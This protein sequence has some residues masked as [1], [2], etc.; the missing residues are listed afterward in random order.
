MDYATSVVSSNTDQIT[1]SASVSATMSFA[2]N[3]NSIALGTLSTSSV[4]SGNVVETIS[5]NARNGWT[6]WVKG[7]Q[8]STTLGALRS[9]TALANISVPA[10]SWNTTYDLSST[11][12]YVIDADATTGSPTINAGYDGANVTSGGISTTLFREMATKT[13]P[14][15]GDQVTINA[16]AKILATQ[17]AANDYTDTLTITAAGSF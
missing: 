8:G 5:T 12:G 6:T 17:T 1:V 9:A 4:T 10:G 14:G 2:L 3:S 16:R 7:T 11:T 13:T 15:S